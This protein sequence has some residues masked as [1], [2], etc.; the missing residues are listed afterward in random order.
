MKYMYT[1][2]ID[3]PYIPSLLGKIKWKVFVFKCLTVSRICFMQLIHS[4]WLLRRLPK[5]MFLCSR[6]VLKLLRRC[7]AI[8]ECHVEWPWKQTDAKN[9][10]NLNS[11]KFT[12]ILSKKKAWIE[13]VVVV[14]ILAVVYFNFDVFYLLR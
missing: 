7:L 11:F 6:P 14:L 3:H 4:F 9:E 2:K 12:L 5:Q 13:E 10:W 8:G 1:C